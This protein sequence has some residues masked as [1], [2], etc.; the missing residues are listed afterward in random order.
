LGSRVYLD[1]YQGSR[2]ILVLLMNF[3]QPAI[4]GQPTRQS[5]NSR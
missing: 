1:Q 3:R 2:V 5:P 4:S